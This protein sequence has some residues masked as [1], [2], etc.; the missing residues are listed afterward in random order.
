MELDPRGAI[1]CGPFRKN[2]GF[3]YN[4]SDGTTHESVTMST[5]EET[6]SHVRVLLITSFGTSAAMTAPIGEPKLPK[7]GFDTFSLLSGIKV[8][9][10][11]Y[12]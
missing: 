5:A 2:S 1:E 3:T 6:R 9:S 8:T 11:Y 12:R 7:E 4:F 10:K